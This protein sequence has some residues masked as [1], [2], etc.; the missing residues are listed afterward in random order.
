MRHRSRKRSCRGANKKSFGP[1][2]RIARGRSLAA[3]AR[4]RD[5]GVRRRPAPPMLRAPS[6]RSRCARPSPD[7]TPSGATGS[8]GA[9]IDRPEPSLQPFQND[10]DADAHQ[11]NEADRGIGAGQIIAL[12]KLV[13][14][15]AE[16]A[17]IDQE[18]DA[19]DVD[20][21]E[22]QSEPQANEDGGQ[23]GRKEY[24]PEL[25]R[26]GEVKAAPDIDQ[27]AAGAGETFE[28]LEDHRG[29]AR[30][31]AHHNDGRRIAPEDHEIERID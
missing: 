24:L 6:R 28:R 16:P 14:E 20:Q 10:E 12:G 9:L 7:A 11:N 1:G 18:L 15:L 27:H 29:D 25:L 21:S 19:D 2:S 22:D 30:S 8:R 3:K 31:E 5:T 13:D 4:R 17:E 26:A 23:R